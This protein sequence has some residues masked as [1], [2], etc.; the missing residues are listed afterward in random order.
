MHVDGKEAEKCFDCPGKMQGVDLNRNYG[1]DWKLNL[2][3]GA[4]ID[5]CSELYPGSEPFS[6]KET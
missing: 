3:Q 6:E 1:V 5:P 4:S 2:A